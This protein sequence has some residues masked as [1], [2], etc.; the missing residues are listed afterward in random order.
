MGRSPAQDLAHAASVA[1]TSSTVL[2][3]TAAVPVTVCTAQGCTSSHLEAP[4]PNP[5][6]TQLHCCGSS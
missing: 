2:G 1:H 6:Q 4:D 5:Q 3:A